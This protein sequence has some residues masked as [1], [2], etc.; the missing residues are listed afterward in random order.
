VSIQKKAVG[1]GQATNKLPPA[2]AHKNVHAKANKSE[3]PL[4]Q[5]T[6]Q[7]RSKYP[8]NYAE[9]LLFFY[10]CCCGLVS[11]SWEAENVDYNW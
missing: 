4:L 11:S 6:S 8:H 3:Q 10:N 5:R 7:D 1:I 2:T 9:A